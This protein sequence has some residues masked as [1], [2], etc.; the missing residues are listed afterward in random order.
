MKKRNLA[1]CLALALTGSLAGCSSAQPAAPSKAETKAEAT[2]AG[3]TTASSGANTAS[4][5]AKEEIFMG[6]ATTG[7]FTYLWGAACAEILNKYI[8]GVNVTA[9]ITTG[10]SENLVRIVT[11]EIPMG[12]AGSNVI[13]QFYDGDSTEG[14]SENKNLR[15]LWVSKPTTF[16]VIV[17]TSSSYQTLEDL[18]GKKI[19]IGNQGGSAAESIYAC[20]KVFGMDEDYFDLQY[21]TMN[22]SKD[23]MITGT[24]DGFITNTSDPHT[25]MTEL[26]MTGNFRFLDMP[27][28]KRDLITKEIPYM[29]KTVRPAGTYEKQDKDVN[30]WGSPY[31][32]VVREDFSEETAYQIAKA[33]DE[34]YDEWV[35]IASNVE[36]STLDA[37][38]NS[39]YAPLHP[40]VERYAKEKGMLK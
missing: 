15:T 9:Q 38:V 7:G 33:L 2:T 36:G 19:S 25:A 21:L 28:D 32:L 17:P 13:A 11:N 8:D 26:F 27:E 39:Y 24:I 23:A 40:G 6:T 22:E 35:G 10:G 3:E 30:G 5:G 20:L 29:S 1:I 37:L 12:I 34:H 31:V 18:K 14:I 16:S 4:S